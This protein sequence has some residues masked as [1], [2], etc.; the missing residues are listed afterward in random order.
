MKFFIIC[1]TWFFMLGCVTSKKDVKTQPRITVIPQDDDLQLPDELYLENRLHGCD[2]ALLYMEHFVTPGIL[3]V[4]VLPE[5]KAE[6]LIAFENSNLC[7]RPYSSSSYF[8]FYIAPECF[9]NLDAQKVYDTFVLPE[10]HQR[11]KD[12]EREA[13]KQGF[14]IGISS[15]GSFGFRILEGKVIVADERPIIDNP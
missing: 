9:L 11:L 1:L 4:S 6:P 7:T 14:A 15:I 13:G 10:F 3:S 12:I 5:L 2:S 8:R